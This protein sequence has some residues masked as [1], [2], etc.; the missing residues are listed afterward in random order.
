MIIGCMGPVCSPVPLDS[1]TVTLFIPDLREHGNRN[2]ALQLR[3]WILCTTPSNGKQLSAASHR[4]KPS[5]QC[6][7]T[8]TR[9]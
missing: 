1:N 5:E 8:S 7:S 9:R 4:Q 2:G 6:F 3:P